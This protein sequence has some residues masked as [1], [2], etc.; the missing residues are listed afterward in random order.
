MYVQK[1]RCTAYLH[2]IPYQQI[3]TIHANS[4]YSLPCRIII[5]IIIVIIANVTVVCGEW[6]YLNHQDQLLQTERL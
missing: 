1:R 4:M 2:D 3:T 6:G 5:S